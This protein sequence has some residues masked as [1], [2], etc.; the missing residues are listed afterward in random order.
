MFKQFGA[1]SARSSLVTTSVPTS[2]SPPPGGRRS[3]L[4]LASYAEIAAIV[5]HHHERVDGR[6]TL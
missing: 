2:R 5:R 6:G 3:F 1:G 4:S